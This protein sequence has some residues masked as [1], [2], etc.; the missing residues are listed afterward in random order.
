MHVS[1]SPEEEQ[2][3]SVAVL[4]ALVEA[5]TIISIAICVFAILVWDWAITLHMEIRYVWKSKWTLGKVLY[6]FTRYIAVVDIF[7]GLFWLRLRNIPDKQTECPVPFTARAWFG[8]VGIEIA[9]L[10]LVLRTWAL[11]GRNRWILAILLVLQ[12]IVFA[13]DGFSLY[14]FVKSVTWGGPELAEV[15]G[16]VLVGASRTQLFSGSLISIAAFEFIIFI[17]TLIFV[18]RKARRNRLTDIIFRDGVTF[19][20]AMTLISVVNVVIMNVVPPEYSNILLLF[21]CVMH[22]IATSR[23]LLHMRE[24][25]NIDAIISSTSHPGVS[26]Q[27]NTSGI[28]SNAWQEHSSPNASAMAVISMTDTIGRRV[29]NDDISMWFGE[30]E[31]I[32]DQ[33]PTTHVGKLVD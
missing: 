19:S 28:Q 30:E 7:L 18:L 5:E 9:E 20:L 24:G 32:E 31:G 21:Q 25:A 10:I 13:Y 27:F 11:W 6:L 2:Q 17:F 26:I 22:S 15:P 14:F 29:F 4:T 12:S 16:C 8:C 3:K 23:I 33:I 1:P